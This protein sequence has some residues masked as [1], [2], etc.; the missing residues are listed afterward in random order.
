VIR[1]KDKYA[2]AALRAYSEVADD[3]DPQW[4]AEVNRLAVKALRHKHRKMP[5]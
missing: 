1:L 2:Y 3:D 5:D 4:A